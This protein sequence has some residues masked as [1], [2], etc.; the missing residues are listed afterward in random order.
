MCDLKRLTEALT[1]VDYSSNSKRMT[2]NECYVNLV[3]MNQFI[4]LNA[5][6]LIITSNSVVV[7]FN[8]LT[9]W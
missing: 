1:E 3:C 5:I 6:R 8:N 9:V 2:V 7:I 4:G